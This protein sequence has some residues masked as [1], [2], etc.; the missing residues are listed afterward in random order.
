MR[1]I[2]S[3]GTVIFSIIPLWFIEH[4]KIDAQRS[5]QTQQKLQQKQLNKNKKDR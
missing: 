1:I 4:Y 3:A 5:Q 2:L